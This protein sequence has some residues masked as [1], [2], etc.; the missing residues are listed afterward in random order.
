MLTEPPGFIHG[1]YQPYIN[2]NWGTYLLSE[3]NEHWVN[4]G[5]SNSEGDE[6]L[7]E[8]DKYVLSSYNKGLGGFNKHGYAKKYL[9]L[10]EERYLS[11]FKNK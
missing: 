11:L 6:I 5:V 1:E 9:K 4:K 7:G 2:L 8:L 3:L 10:V